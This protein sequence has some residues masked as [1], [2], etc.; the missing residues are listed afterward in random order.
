MRDER[1]V[2]VAAHAA[3]RPY[4]ARG[5]PAAC[6]NHVRVVLA[7][8]DGVEG[9]RFVHEALVPAASE[10]AC[11]EEDDKDQN[12]ETDYAENRA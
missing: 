2:R 11:P 9:Y 4:I 10:E 7:E 5:R 3:G 1:T 12:D 6:L 8:V